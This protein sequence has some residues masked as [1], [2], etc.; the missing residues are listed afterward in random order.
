MLLFMSILIFFVFIYYYYCLD[1]MHKEIVKKLSKL[2]QLPEIKIEESEGIVSTYKKR[3]LFPL[4]LKKHLLCSSNLLEHVFSEI[5]T[6]QPKLMKST[7]TDRY[8]NNI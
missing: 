5:V 8:L 3:D 7:V 1:V 6:H 4:N 2:L